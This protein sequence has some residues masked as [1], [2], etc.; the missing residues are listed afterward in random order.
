ME[1]GDNSVNFDLRFWI[2]DA[3]NGTS[4]VRSDVLL[5]IWDMLAEQGVEIPFPQRDLHIK[6]A[7]KALRDALESE[8]AAPVSNLREG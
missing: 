4:N 3:A 2:N 8:A 5:A 6:S 7:P 1:F